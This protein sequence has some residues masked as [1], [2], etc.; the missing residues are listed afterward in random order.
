MGISREQFEQM[1]ATVAYENI[2][3]ENMN[4]ARMLA[5]SPII[6]PDAEFF[7]FATTHDGQPVRLYYEWE[8]V[9]NGERLKK[10]REI[11]RTSMENARKYND[12][13]LKDVPGDDP[14]TEKDVD[15]QETERNLKSRLDENKVS[16]DIKQYGD[17]G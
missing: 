15:D 1:R 9:W 3:Q 11:R 17:Q 7:Y 12:D 14:D 16:G 6:R 10:Y 8:E 13:R 4:L 2:R 5:N